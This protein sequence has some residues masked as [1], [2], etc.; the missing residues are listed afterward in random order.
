MK[1]L[2]AA[3]M[4][5]SVA[6][7]APAA[8]AAFPGRNGR[9]AFERDQDCFN[10]VINIVTSD[11][12]GG[13]RA[14]VLPIPT[15]SNIEK[16]RQP[17]WSP[18]GARLAYYQDALIANSNPDG[19]DQHTFSATLFDEEPTW[20]PD[21]T[22]IAWAGDG[23]SATDIWAA[24]PDGTNAVQLTSGAGS[25][26]QPAWSPDGSKIAFTSARDGDEEIFVMNSD[27]TG[28][29]PITSN[30]IVDQYPNWSPDG[31]RIV[32][33]RALEI[34]TMDAN[35]ANQ[36][37][38]TPN[39]VADRTPAWSPD[40]TRIVF[41]R[42]DDI[43]T[44]STGGGAEANVTHSISSCEGTPDWQ[45][46]PV[47]AYPRPK[48]ATPTYLFFVPAYAACTSPDR[49]HGA[50]LSFGSCSPPLRR[51]SELTMGT[52]DANGER[53]KSIGFAVLR[54][55]V[56]N[57]ATAADEADVLI[58]FSVTDVRDSGDLA[59]YAGALEAR[60]TLRIT[61]R[62]NSPSPGGPGA[63]TVTDLPFPFAVPCTVTLDT[64]V[65]STCAVNTTA[66]AVAP[67]AVKEGRRSIWAL[68]G[69]EVHDA[70]GDVFLTQGLFVP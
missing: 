9:I 17:A 37:Q 27:G 42:G 62:D 1:R 55:K 32:F 51:S 34:W 57:P 38:I 35:G 40:G 44:M 53:A 14:E 30:T 22:R 33:E 2:V 65:G 67:G 26:F 61:D 68:N 48:G 3:V 23:P 64:T 63:G 56:G 12:D 39:G 31:T 16:R 20:S 18:D 47:N 4:L 50:P 13:S 52:P 5:A 69:F 7:G 43:W 11:S 8:H 15:G 19:S 21:G 25:N 60:P 36:A 24:D 28:Q 10:E 45:P 49:A 58:A 29:V 41:E 70:N 59:D 46:I 6:I 66:D 54:A